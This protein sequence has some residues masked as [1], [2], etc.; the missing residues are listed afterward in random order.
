MALSGTNLG[1]D[2]SILFRGVAALGD[3]EMGMEMEHTGSITN[4]EFSV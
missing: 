2:V 3:I 1:A 4:H